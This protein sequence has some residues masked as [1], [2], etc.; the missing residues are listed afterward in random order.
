[1]G[2]TPPANPDDADEA[3]RLARDADAVV[4]VGGL[5][6]YLEGEEM[7][8]NLDGFLGGDRTRIELPSAQDRLLRALVA[9]GKP[10]VFVCC[11]GSAIAMP[12][13]AEHVPAIVQA[14]YPGQAGG[15][16]VGEVLF[17][18]VNPSGRLP[19]T[20]YAS[21]ADLPPFADYS[22]ANRTYRYFTG[23]PLFPFG[24]GLSYTQFRYDR[25]RPIANVAADGTAHLTLT[26]TNVGDRD[27]DEVVQAYARPPA[28]P[29]VDGERVPVRQLVAFQRVSLAKG[30]SADVTLDIPAATLRRWD[31]AR[32][33][34]TVR[35]GAYAIDVGPSSAD[36]R[37]TTTLQ[38]SA[39]AT[40]P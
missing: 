7:G 3:V 25:F 28:A 20:V 5:D 19:V 27:G 32:Q 10:V 2:R 30:A 8:I 35:P 16:A 15:T 40:R 1:M 37:W 29:P 26:V 39:A 4:F 21:T 6:S 11:S 14:W 13:A 23:T 33:A 17:G 12:W 22:M 31:A 38:V 18:T 36:V 24:H 9:T 34:E